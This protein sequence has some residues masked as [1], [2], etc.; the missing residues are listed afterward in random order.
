MKKT[1]TFVLMLFF[2]AHFALAQTVKFVDESGNTI[3]NGT[4]LE[5][6]EA[7]EDEW[8]DMLIPT[9]LFVENTTNKDIYVGIDFNVK[10]LPNGAFQI[11]FP[12][13]CMNISETGE[14]KT[15]EGLME[16]NA[17]QDLKAEWIPDENG[18]GTCTVELQAN[19][20]VYNTI[21]KKYT[22]DEEGPKI[23]VNMVCKDPA[24]VKN[25]EKDVKILSRYNLVGQQMSSLQKCVSIVKL[26]NGKTVKMIN[27]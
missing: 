20:Y 16:A 5:V 15:P 27:K 12:Q 8:G 14:K 21:T 10:N 13:N 22:L 17:K 1:F 2:T 25:I 26:D 7:V 24:S 11:C 4:T 23:T 3:A 18:F 19:V 6:S 9:G